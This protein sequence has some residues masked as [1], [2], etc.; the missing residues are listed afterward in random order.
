MSR[1]HG[2]CGAGGFLARTQGERQMVGT[3]I[4]KVFGVDG[5]PV[6][7]LSLGASA[8]VVR[9][10]FSSAAVFEWE[11]DN[12]RGRLIN[13]NG[14]AGSWIHEGEEDEDS[15]RASQAAFEKMCQDE[16]ELFGEDPFADPFLLE[17]IGYTSIPKLAFLKPPVEYHDDLTEF[18]I[19]LG[20]PP[21][22]TEEEKEKLQELWLRKTAELDHRK[23]PLIAPSPHDPTTISSFLDMIDNEYGGNYETEEEEQ[24]SGWTAHNGSG[25]CGESVE[26]SSEFHA[27]TTLHKVENSDMNEF[28]PIPGLQQP[29][30][31]IS[32]GTP[33]S[34]P[35]T[36]VP[37]DSSTTPTATSSTP[38]PPCLTASTPAPRLEDL[39]HSLS[40][41]TTPPAPRAPVPLSASPIALAP[42]AKSRNTSRPFTSP[43]HTSI[44]TWPP[45]I[46]PDNQ[47]NFV[48]TATVV[49]A[50]FSGPT[51][52]VSLGIASPPDHTSVNSLTLQN[53][54]AAVP[55]SP[56]STK[57]I[58]PSTRSL[59]SLSTALLPAKT[60][61]IEDDV[62]MKDDSIVEQV[63][64]QGIRG[65]SS[66]DGGREMDALW[67]LAAMRW[68]D[69]PEGGT[70]SCGG[71]DGK[72]AGETSRDEAGCVGLGFED[73]GPRA[74]VEGGIKEI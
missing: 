21:V 6:E 16:I 33:D 72:T 11:T 18:Y 4:H 14:E 49:T 12:M 17:K 20:S 63:E 19:L 8:D 61:H 34:K 26:V 60:V 57:Q 15:L 55:S 52:P 22:D 47:L 68:A 5:G 43:S 2:L 58:F 40:T 66:D 9:V 74:R 44:T 25:N 67:I 54:S 53:A 41:S 3:N 13:A 23:T 39:R 56:S 51:S 27:I 30:P 70:L 48:P 31:Q 62:A 29:P 24:N 36:E 59:K 10:H 64:E 65:V 37:L 42:T 28:N 35:S 7:E 73:A 50:T 71:I 45:H 1:I 32:A 46:G 69:E 38:S